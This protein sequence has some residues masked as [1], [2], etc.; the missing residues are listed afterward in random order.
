MED[1]GFLR[2][3]LF[4]GFDLDN[5]VALIVSCPAMDETEPMADQLQASRNKDWIRALTLGW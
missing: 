1:K 2:Q 5:N 3:T 4:K